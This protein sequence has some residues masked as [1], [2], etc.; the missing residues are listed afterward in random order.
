MLLAKA[1]H[2]AKPNFKRVRKPTLP[3]GVVWLSLTQEER[4]TEGMRGQGTVL[5]GGHGWNLFCLEAVHA[6]GCFSLGTSV[7][8]LESPSP[9]TA[10]GS[11]P[12]GADDTSPL[13]GSFWCS[14]QVT[15]ALCSA[16]AGRPPGW[17]P[18]RP[19]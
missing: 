17:G 19:R 4:R 10:L 14:T 8:A 6:K 12:S 9:V 5:P 18:T 11:S 2:M 1:N 16:P 7:G 13:S 3:V 15:R